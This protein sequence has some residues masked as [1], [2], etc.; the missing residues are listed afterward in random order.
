MEATV[1]ETLRRKL[2]Q[3]RTMAETA[4]RQSMEAKQ[5]SDPATAIPALQRNLEL[6]ASAVRDLA[7]ALEQNL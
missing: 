4:V 7:F 2:M 1:D 6:L 5:S 3:A